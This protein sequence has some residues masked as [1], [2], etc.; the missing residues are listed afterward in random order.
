MATKPPRKRQA[1]YF[2]GETPAKCTHCGSI[3][4][5]VVRTVPMSSGSVRRRRE[6]RDCAKAFTTSQSPAMAATAQKGGE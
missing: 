4:T 5:D 6:C 2:P 1:S 3:R